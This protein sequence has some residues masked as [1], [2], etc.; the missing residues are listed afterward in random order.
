MG[1]SHEFTGKCG[2]SPHTLPK[3]GT[4]TLNADHCLANAKQ[5]KTSGQKCPIVCK[6]SA[7]TSGN[8][9]HKRR[10][11]KEKEP[12]AQPISSGKAKAWYTMLCHLFSVPMK[13]QLTTSNSIH[14][15]VELPINDVDSHTKILKTQR[16][17]CPN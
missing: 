10:T 1:G 15:L 7:K 6:R 14:K 5:E 2:S 16:A 17:V 3:G 8:D 11:Q 9:T 4:S 13:R 12:K